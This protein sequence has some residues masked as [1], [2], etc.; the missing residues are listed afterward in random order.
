MDFEQ[1]FSLLRDRY[2]ASLP[3]KRSALQAA[4]I[5]VRDA[6]TDARARREL[7]TLLHRLAGSAPAY[8]QPDLGALAAKACALVVGDE[9][10]ADVDAR[11]R[12][13]V[14]LAPVVVQLLGAL[15]TLVQAQKRSADALQ[16]GNTSPLRVILIE[17]DEEQATAIGATLVAHG[18]EVRHAVHAESLWQVVTTWPCDAIVIDYW[19]GAGTANDIV[20]LIRDEPSFSAIALICLTVETSPAKLQ[21]VLDGGCDRVLSKREEP[22][23]IVDVLRKS[24]AERR[25][26]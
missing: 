2:H 1:R 24:V 22:K 10:E 14:E 18:C 20:R 4:W 19:L 25:A 7:R 3:D 12:N 6:S 8:G 17:D 16:S 9:D 13:D 11:N 5:A 15:D 23:R 26:R 21:G